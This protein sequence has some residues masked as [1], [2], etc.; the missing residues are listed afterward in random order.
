MLSEDCWNF[1]ILW[2]QGLALRGN[3]GDDDSNFI[4]TLKLRAKDI[5]QLTDWMKQ[6]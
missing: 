1:T 2:R 6:K 3:N 4:Q 5:L